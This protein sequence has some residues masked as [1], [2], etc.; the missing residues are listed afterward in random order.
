[1]ICKHVFHTI[2]LILRKHTF[3]AVDEI[4]SKKS[5]IDQQKCWYSKEVFKQQLKQENQHR[6]IF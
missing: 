4:Y 3:P 5:A 1:M 2:N 6:N